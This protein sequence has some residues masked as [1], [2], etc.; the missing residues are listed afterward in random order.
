MSLHQ[1][2]GAVPSASPGRRPRLGTASARSTLL[3]VLGEFVHPRGDGVWTS[4]LVAALA[5]LDI[6]EKAARQALTR[7][8]AERIL[9][10]TRHGRRVLWRLT[11]A[12]TALLEEGTRHIYGFMRDRR[13]WD[14]RW[15]VVSVAIPEAQRRLRHRLRTRLTWLGLGTPTPGLWVSP[16]ATKASLVRDA[17]ADLGLQ[18]R[19]FAWTGPMADTGDQRLLLAQAWDL[20]DVERRYHEFLQDFGR[21]EASS[22]LEAFVAQVQM[23]EA[24]RRFPFLDPELPRELLDHDWPGPRAADAFHDRHQRWEKGAQHAWERFQASGGPHP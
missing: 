6:E 24:W 10:S 19:A 12:G 14:G 2:H 13:A 16:D 21:R 11:P 22:D 9:E 17:V 5:A 20:D 15:L 4:T 8:A 18:G 1:E 7:T 23:I 3:T